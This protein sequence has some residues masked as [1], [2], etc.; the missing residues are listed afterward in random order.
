MIDQQIDQ[1]KEG[2]VVGPFLNGDKVQLV[3]VYETGEEEQAKET[4]P[5]KP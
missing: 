1:S 5:Y 4:Y 3:K 2:D